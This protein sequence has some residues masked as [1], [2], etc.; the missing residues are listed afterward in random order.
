M[1]IVAAFICVKSWLMWSSSGAVKC[2]NKEEARTMG[3]LQYTNIHYIKSKSDCN[4][5]QRKQKKSSALHVRQSLHTFC[6]S[7]QWVLWVL[8]AWLMERVTTWDT[9]SPPRRRRRT[10]PSASSTRTETRVVPRPTIQHA[11]SSCVTTTQWV[12]ELLSE[13]SSNEISCELF[14]WEFSDIVRCTAPVC[15]Y[16][17]RAKHTNIVVTCEKKEKM[18]LKFKK[19]YSHGDACKEQVKLEE[20]VRLNF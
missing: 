11:S 7:P 17:L 2:C 20:D 12:S 9:S 3:T 1:K 10:A 6:S 18:D 4:W 5:N 8:V 14:I 13:L 15:V 19:R 16:P